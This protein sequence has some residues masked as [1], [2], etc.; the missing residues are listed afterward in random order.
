MGHGIFTYF[1][2][3]EIRSVP[4][5]EKVYPEFLKVPVCEKVYRHAE[6]LGFEQSPTLNASISGNITVATRKLPVKK[7]EQTEKEESSEDLRER[8]SLV[9]DAPN[10]TNEYLTDLLANMIEKCKE[11]FKE[12][13][14]IDSDGAVSYTHLTLPTI[15]LV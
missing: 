14:F 13:E 3:E 7:E 4:A 5:G 8:I 12:I 15:L 1:L 6:S 10:I 9:N 11:H 2:C